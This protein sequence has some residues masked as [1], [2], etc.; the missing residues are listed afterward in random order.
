[1][2]KTILKVNIL[3]LS[4]MVAAFTMQ[5]QQ[6]CMGELKKTFAAEKK[7]IADAFAQNTGWHMRY[8]MSS[9]YLNPRSKKYE[10]VSSK[11]EVIAGAYMRYKKTDNIEVFIDDNDIFTVN[12]RTNS[13]L[14]TYT[15]P[16]DL[17]IKDDVESLAM[18]DS[19]LKLMDVG[20]CKTIKLENKDMLSILLTSAKRD[21]PFTKV[22]IYIDPVNYTMQRMHAEMNMDYQKDVKE[23]TLMIL[24]KNN[25]P[26]EPVWTHIADKFLDPAGKLK[27]PYK[28]YTLDEPA[29]RAKE[30]AESAKKKKKS[31]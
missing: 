28:K 9:E 25:L 27:E 30:S 8:S 2:K 29:K 15:K 22:V 12:K 6:S 26:L 4:F 18:Q 11:G 21:C 3:C 23:Y 31:K 24:E 10:T 13:I 20:E 16:G 17:K 5:A 19:V 14:H 1:M 7:L